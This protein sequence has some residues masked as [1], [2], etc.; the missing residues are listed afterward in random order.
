MGLTPL[1]ARTMNN[2][3]LRRC[4]LISLSAI[5][6]GTGL[7]PL[8]SLGHLAFAQ[9]VPDSTLPSNS[10]VSENGEISTITGGTVSGDYL[11][12]S[13]ETFSIVDGA[14]ASF[15]HSAAIDSIITRVTGGT[16]S[17][18]NGLL[19]A[20]GN[21]DFFLLNPNGIVFGADA[22]LN[23]GGS[24]IGS[25]ADHILFDDD[26]VFSA[27]DPQAPPLLT[28]NTTLG[29]QYGATP[30]PITVQGAG[31]NLTTDENT[32][33]VIL[34]NRPDGLDVSAGQTLALI[35]GDVS[36]DG[37]NL[38]APTGRVILGST[39]NN[40][41]TLTDD[42]NGWSADYGSGSILG[43]I[44][45]SGAASVLTS[46]EGG[47]EIQLT[48]QAVRIVEGA[49]LLANT[50][51]AEDAVGISIQ[52]SELLRVHGA[53]LDNEGEVIFPTSIFSEVN[54]DA[55]G[56]GGN[57]R[58]TTPRLRIAAGAQISASTLG[59][60]DAGDI[61]VSANRV[62]ILGGAA[63]T[64]SGLFVNVLNPDTEGNG[65]TLSIV[66]QRL[67]IT[68]G[69]EIAANTE[70]IG[71]SGTITLDVDAVNVVAG[72]FGLG[73][74]GIFAQSTEGSTGRGG[75]LFIESDRLQVIGGA[76][77]QVLPF[78]S[79][80]GGR[81]DIVA[82]Q[83]LLD[84]QSPNGSPSAISAVV[85]SDA[86]GQGGQI[87]IE[88]EQLEIINGAQLTTATNGSGDAGS[89][90]VNAD[91]ILLVGGDDLATIISS[92][93]EAN[94]T[95]KGGRLAIT[96]DTLTLMD[97]AQIST[98]T[99]S[100][101]PAGDLTIRARTIDIEGRNNLARS[102]IVS[103]AIV[104][105]GA[106][107]QMVIDTETLTI[108]DGGIVTAS[109]FPTVDNRRPGQGPAGNVVIQADR[110]D[111][112]TG[113]ITASTSVGDRGNIRLDSELL[114]LRDR[115]LI[116]TN[117]DSATGGNI[118]ISS[119]NI[120]AFNNS[121]ITANANQGIGG[122]VVITANGLFGI[123]FRD[124][125]TPQSDITVTSNLGPQFD[126][127]VDL[128]TP[129]VDPLQGVLDLPNILLD[130]NIEVVA[131]CEQLQGNELIITGRGGL[132]TTATQFTKAPAVW[133]DLRP[134]LLSELLSE[135]RPELRPNISRSIPIENPAESVD[136]GM[137]RQ[138]SLDRHPQSFV[139]PSTPLEA[140]S[141]QVGTDGHITLLA[142]SGT[143]S[144]IHQG[145]ARCY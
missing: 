19:E 35:G 24:F 78:A 68:G 122:R 14:T 57:I 139:P 140:K 6:S 136:A 79:G 2:G 37:G 71:D 98:S 126:G 60:G 121:D 58:I 89:L 42:G 100:N 39:A 111:L 77:I 70:G 85:G 118:E 38:T 7:L 84:G 29:L 81:L 86:S 110:I 116:T 87:A 83:I 18:I 72:A 74:S 64:P 137:T 33:E 63:T 80:A 10:V 67:D 113:E 119:E 43:D 124:A 5:L 76:V 4:W 103:V 92:A 26:S 22:Q 44:A 15:D 9:I 52:A 41:V 62:N 120:V 135:L 102:G 134:E 50:L 17:I 31:N 59:R 65:G 112:D 55:S 144:I 104:G 123:Q 56:S 91:H 109:N 21:A 73:A 51:G 69:A 32:L 54:P 107:G 1:L 45:L 88:T 75:A 143:D 96:T 61:E 20:Q 133:A 8:N 36:L 23:I 101:E 129:D 47:G 115:S 117:A 48:G 94:G 132:P 66:A 99:Q 138:T 82:D 40:T 108:R 53:V 27:V 13:F 141:W 114:F 12:H 125:L 106:G 90:Q 49:A 127:V 142:S 105:D 97:G 30:G 131:A 25:S 11:F 128:S 16:E 130:P 3:H 93:V 46:G 145:I 28:V 95:G 34:S